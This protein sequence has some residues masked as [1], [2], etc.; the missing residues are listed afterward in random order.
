MDRQEHL[1][2]QSGNR[3]VAFSIGNYLHPAARTDAQG[4]DGCGLLHEMS[5]GL[6]D[7]AL[8]SE[9]VL[10][11]TQCLSYLTIELRGAIPEQLRPALGRYAY[12]ATSARRCAR[13][14]RHR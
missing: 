2:H 7:G 1:P 9:H 12:G 14:T 5:R 4:L 13:T 8:V 6:S 10:D 3:V 11:A